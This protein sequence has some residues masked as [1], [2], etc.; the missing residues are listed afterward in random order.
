MKKKPLRLCTLLLVLF[1]I[2]GIGV[3]VFYSIIRYNSEK[4]IQYLHAEER[5]MDFHLDTHSDRFMP[6]FYGIDR[7]GIFDYIASVE[8]VPESDNYIAVSFSDTSNNF[9]YGYIIYDQFRASMTD[10]QYNKISEYLNSETGNENTYYELL[11]TYYS[12]IDEQIVPITIEIVETQEDHVWY[13]QDTPI[14]TFEL[15]PSVKLTNEVKEGSQSRRNII[16]RDFFFGLR[17]VSRMNEIVDKGRQDSDFPVL[18]YLGDFEYAY[19]QTSN[20]YEPVGDGEVHLSGYSVILEGDYNVYTVTYIETFNV[21]EHCI[22]DIKLVSTYTVILFFVM[23]ILLSLVVYMYIKKQ[24]EQERNLITITNSL[25][26]NLKTPLFVISG[27]AEN[28]EAISENTEQKS[29]CDAILSQVEVM[30]ERVKKMFELSRMT[31]DVYKLN[32]QKFSLSEL[33]KEIISSYSNIDKEIIFECDSDVLISA[34]KPLIG[35]VIEN[36][37]D[38][39]LRYGEGDKVIVS[40]EGKTFSVSNT[41][42]YLTKRDLKRIFKPY[43]RHPKNGQKSG[44]GIGLSLTKRILKLHKFKLT[45]SIKNNIFTITFVATTK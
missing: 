40:L 42:G 34:D 2:L 8:E 16:D 29:Y 9:E 5:Y 31:S 39:A 43:Y 33:A 27:N 36:L 22:D 19:R 11:C 32:L 15:N 38:N 28:L 1:L 12:F 4:E 41:C 21:M 20:S 24:L 30:D 13:A 45:T 44:N 14:E 18:Y 25:A 17:S 6:N 3:S 7:F 35:S 23:G 37:I 10:E 26:H